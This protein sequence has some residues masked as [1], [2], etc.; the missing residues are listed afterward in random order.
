MIKLYDVKKLLFFKSLKYDEQ[1]EMPCESR[2]IK[3]LIFDDCW[4][5]RA[6]YQLNGGLTRM[7][8]SEAWLEG[9][10]KMVCF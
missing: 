3:H 5:L 7:S 2:E 6:K 9:M 1:C 10:E 4:K 8:T